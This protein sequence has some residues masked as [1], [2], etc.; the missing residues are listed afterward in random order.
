M[1][2]LYVKS[3]WRETLEN[4]LISDCVLSKD[5]LCNAFFCAFY[6]N[7]CNLDNLEKLVYNQ[8]DIKMVLGQNTSLPAVFLT[9]RAN[10]SKVL[11][12]VSFLLNLTT[13][14][15][16][17]WGH[18]HLCVKCPDCLKRLIVTLSCKLVFV[19]CSVQNFFF[20]WFV[21]TSLISLPEIIVLSCFGTLCEWL[22]IFIIHVDCQS[23]V[24]CISFVSKLY[25]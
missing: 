9:G 11:L 5:K 15:S 12:H 24:M 4:H 8:N 25:P 22:C 2:R 1:Y 19:S 18:E 14:F 7:V 17:L 20:H 21:S 6:I 3:L 13:Y 23:I 10:V 16:F